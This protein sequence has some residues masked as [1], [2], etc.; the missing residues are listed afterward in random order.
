[1]NLISRFVR[2]YTTMRLCNI[3]YRPKS[4]TNLD[5]TYTIRIGNRKQF[6]FKRIL[7]RIVLGP[8][9]IILKKTNILYEPIQHACIHFT[10]LCRIRAFITT[11]FVKRTWK[12]V[13]RICFVSYLPFMYYETK[14]KAFD[15]EK[16]VLHKLTNMKWPSIVIHVQLL[17]TLNVRGPSYLG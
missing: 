7:D 11:I 15:F 6:C 2:N 4:I 1:M 5:K 16:A 8:G 13:L 9:E 12:H 3:P 10:V 17:L 14:S